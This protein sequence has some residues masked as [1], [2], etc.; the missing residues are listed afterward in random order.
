MAGDSTSPT[1]RATHRSNSSSAPIRF[2]VGKRSWRSR[3]SSAGSSPRVIAHT[4]RGLRATKTLPFDSQ[5]KRRSVALP[6]LMSADQR[7]ELLKGEAAGALFAKLLTQA[8][9]FALPRRG[10]LRRD[11]R[12]AQTCLVPIF[13]CR[14]QSLRCPRVASELFRH[15]HNRNAGEERHDST[16]TETAA[17]S[18]DSRTNWAR[19]DGSSGTRNFLS[20]SRMRR[21]VRVGA[22]RSTAQRPS[23]SKDSFP[24][25]GVNPL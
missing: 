9:R 8:A 20:P 24:N 1:T 13:R 11:L 23:C 25:G 5:Q 14:A 15:N 6:R 3:T 7:L 10:D 12:T 22:F 16:K 21:P 2:A 18:S 19:Q 17:L 4:P